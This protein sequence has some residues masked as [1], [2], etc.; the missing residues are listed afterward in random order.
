MPRSHV[1]RIVALAALALGLP[2]VHAAPVLITSDF[3][4]TATAFNGFESVPT[5]NSITFDGGSG[6]YAEQGIQ[7]EQVSRDNPA[8]SIIVGGAIPMEGLRF[9]VPNN[10]DEGHTRIS[11]ESGADFDAVSLLFRAGG[12]ANVAYTLLDDGL[13][14]LAGTLAAA[15]GSD[16]RIGFAG[17]GFDTLLLRSG[18]LGAGVGHGVFQSLWVD[19]IKVGA[20][21]V[22]L[23]APATPLL[24]LTALALA[25]ASRRA[26]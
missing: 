9:W 17:G 20:A 26:R 6:P 18:D 10:G 3:I 7:V 19:S 2:T 14:V 12:T 5:A 8:N 11:L 24:V 16:G 4:T 23:P 25:L 22:P 1:Q 21:G 15:L 13:I